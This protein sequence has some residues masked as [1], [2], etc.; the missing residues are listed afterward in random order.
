M[1]QVSVVIPA[2]NA[3]RFLTEA[4][5]SVL[6]QVDVRAQ[7]IVVNDGST[8]PFEPRVLALRQHL[9]WVNRSNGGPAAARNTGLDRVVAPFVAFL[10]ADDLLADGCLARAIAELERGPG[11]DGVHGLTRLLTNAQ[12]LGT[13][14]VDAWQLTGTPWRS[15]QLGSVVVRRSV[16]DQWRFDPALKT[17]EDLD[18]FVRLRDAGTKMILSDEVTLKY[19]IHGGNMT[20]RMTPEQTNTHSILKRAVERRRARE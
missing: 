13:E 5:E 17:G 10:D 16:T 14:L 19:R 7:I 4:I 8:Q 18:W 2:Y 9:D 1:R 15:P 11:M 6:S 12:T 20:T 3:G